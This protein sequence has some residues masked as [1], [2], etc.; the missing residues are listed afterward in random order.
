MAKAIA[1]Y[2]GGIHYLAQ[3]ALRADGTLFVRVQ[4]KSHYGYQWSKWKVRTQYG[5]GHIPDYVAVGFND[6]RRVDG[7]NYLN[8]KCR[9][10]NT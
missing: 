8:F 3:A 10:P 9:L 7:L 4:K 1:K 5:K 6:L 2:A